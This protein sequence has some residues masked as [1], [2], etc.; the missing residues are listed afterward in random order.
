MNYYSSDILI[1]GGGIAASMAAIEAAKLG[2]KV[3]LVDKGML[4]RSGLSA[5]TGGGVCAAITPPDDWQTHA[6][7]AL[8]I[9][10]INDPLL[11]EIM[12]REAPKRLEEVREFGVKFHTN[13]QGEVQQIGGPTFAHPRIALAV[14]GG[15]AMTEVLRKEALHRGVRVVEDL[16]VTEIVEIDGRAVGAVGVSKTDGG[17]YEFH[18]KAVILAAGGGEGVY[19]YVSSNYVCTGD[20]YTLALTAGAKLA[21]MEFQEFGLVPC[22][23]GVITPAAG[24]GELINNG[25]VIL[26]ESGDSVSTLYPTK[27]FIQAMHEQVFVKHSK[28]FLDALVIEDKKLRSF[29]S[30]PLLAAKLREGGV[31]F[32]KHPRFEIMPALRKFYGGIVIDEQCRTLVE[33]LFAAGE[34]T[35]GSQGARRLEGD[36]I[37]GALVF[38]KRAGRAA[39]AY[40]RSVNAP[41]EHDFTESLQRLRQNLSGRGQGGSNSVSSL[42][43]R[44]RQVMWE[45]VGIIRSEEKILSA[46][47]EIQE[48]LETLERGRFTPIAKKAE[49]L[50]PLELK[51]MLRTAEIVT[52]AALMRKESRGFHFRT[53][54][55]QQDDENWVKWIIITKRKGTEEL[56]IELAEIPH[57]SQSYRPPSEPPFRPIIADFVSD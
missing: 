27:P 8:K 28:V 41:P 21:N 16:M 2:A 9:G 38:G 22:P 15:Y 25:A 45:N 29:S 36:G 1:I 20:S 26:S 6:S 47:N 44:L 52:R 4:G 34:C 51:N 42:K 40:A 13:D 43:A 5:T 50:G 54:Y 7:D 46:I 35:T 48:M 11:T 55:P 37:G 12:A 3:C 17:V 39:V 57:R 32:W 56:N 30:G 24:I 53:D 33:G 19:R 14:G 49:I 31:D 10:T 23:G 18:S